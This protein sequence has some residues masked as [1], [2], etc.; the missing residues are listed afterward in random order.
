[1]L[2]TAERVAAEGEFEKAELD[3][4]AVRRYE[5]YLDALADDRA[6]QREWMVPIVAGSRRKPVEIDEDW[7]VRPIVREELAALG[8]VQEGGVVSYGTQTHPAD[9]CAGMVVT[10]DAAVARARDRRPRRR[11]L[12]T[13]FARVE[14]GRCRRRRCPPPGRRSPTPGSSIGQV[15]VIKTHN[16]FAVNDVW[17][18]RELGVDADEHE[19]V[20][21]AASSTAIRRRPTG[22]RGIVELMHALVRARRRHRPL[23]RLRGRRHRRRARRRGRGV[24]AP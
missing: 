6:F 4:L 11:V 23:H 22:A 21:L 12:A 24:T 8:P 18:A 10:S 3:E 13:G 5:Q 19:P 14:P 15:D 16:P 7:G 20:R 1:M 9:G 17:F 2:A